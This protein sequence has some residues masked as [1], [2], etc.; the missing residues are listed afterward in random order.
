M[1]CNCSTTSC[2]S[3]MR[4]YMRIDNIIFNKQYVSRLEFKGLKL[5]IYYA[6]ECNPYVFDLNSEKS[7]AQIANYLLEL[8][9]CEAPQEDMSIDDHSKLI[10]L[11]VEDQHPLSAIIGLTPALENLK[12]KRLDFTAEYQQD[13]FPLDSDLTN[14]TSLVF[15]DGLLKSALD[16]TIT[17]SDITFN[18]PLQLG[19]KVTILYNN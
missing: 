13:V 7:N 12:I 6:G 2:G 8:N 3:N 19:S 14:L 17:T 9:T 10:N 5:Y 16:Y 18:E 15:V 4:S 1:S 11:D